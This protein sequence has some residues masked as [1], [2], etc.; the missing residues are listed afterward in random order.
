MVDLAT[1]HVEGTTAPSRAL[2]ALQWLAKHAALDWAVADPA[3]E[4]G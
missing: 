1:F 3:S 2:P 4:V